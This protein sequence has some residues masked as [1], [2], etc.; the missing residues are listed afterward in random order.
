MI[1][2]LLG[3]EITYNG[4]QLSSLFINDAVGPADDAAVAFFGPADVPTEN[5]VDEED[6]LAGLTIKS[7]RMVHFL[8]RLKGRDL[9]TSVAVQR[10]C[11]A[12]ILEILISSASRSGLTRDGDDIY[13]ASHTGKRKLTVSIATTGRAGDAFIHIGV[14]VTAEGAPV[15]A[16]GL[17]DLGVDENVFAADTLALIGLEVTGIARA[18]AKVRPVE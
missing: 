6:R 11:V 18:V 9:D 16:I 7:K 17:T 5:L 8:V 13:L 12:G 15:P 1:T 14:N 2:K 3:Q 4:T 10:L